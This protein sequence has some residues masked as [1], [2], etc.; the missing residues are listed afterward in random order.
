MIDSQERDSF[1]EPDIHLCIDFDEQSYDE[2]LEF[3]R[4]VD[5]N[6]ELV[7]GH[8]ELEQHPPMTE[9]GNRYKRRRTHTRGYPRC[10]KPWVYWW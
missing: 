10:D 6:L 9:D 4:L 5:L 3:L 8:N 7:I 2:H 1:Y